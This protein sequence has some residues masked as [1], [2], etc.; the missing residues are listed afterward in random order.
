MTAND[1]IKANIVV[2]SIHSLSMLFFFIAAYD[3]VAERSQA[4]KSKRLIKKLE[5]MSFHALI[6][7]G[8]G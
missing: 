2:K 4:L 3:S 8:L 5:K 1:T 7:L 6:P